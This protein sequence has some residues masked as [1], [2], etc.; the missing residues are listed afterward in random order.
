M[1]KSNP[2]TVVIGISAAIIE[3]NAKTSQKNLQLNLTYDLAVLLLGIQPKKMKS[4]YQRANS[5]PRGYSLQPGSG[6]SLSTDTWVRAVQQVHKVEYHPPIICRD[7]CNITRYSVKWNR[8]GMEM[9]NT[10]FS[11]LCVESKQRQNN[12]QNQ[13]PKLT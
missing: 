11:S 4:A 2:H 12:N 13:T 6:V 9:T 7:V 1:K 3:N 8:L 5:R 10:G